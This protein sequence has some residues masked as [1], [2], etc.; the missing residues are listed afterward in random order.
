[1]KRNLF[2]ISGHADVS[3]LRSALKV[4]A[5]DYLLKPVDL[6]ELEDIL[7]KTI[8]VCKENQHRR[9][10]QEY[11]REQLDENLPILREQFFL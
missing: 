6:Q 8:H 3:Y 11:L 2:F 4:K 10:Q 7:T 9:E 1:M 5:I